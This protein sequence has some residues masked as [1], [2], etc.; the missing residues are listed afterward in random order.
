MR[1]EKT[2][3]AGKL[4]VL[5]GSWMVCAGLVL[6]ASASAA[7]SV[8]WANGSGSTISFANLDGSGGGNLNTTG[9]NVARP[10][11]VAVDPAAGRVY[12]A[13]HSGE[14]ISF[15]NLN[16]SGGG[17]LN[18]AGAS[19][20]GPEGVAI[21]P[22]AGLVYWANDAGSTISFA[23]LNGSG[24]G[25]LKTTG[26]TVS[27]PRGLAVD[28]AAGMIYWANN[29]GS[30]IAFAN[31]DGSGGGE[32]KTT[33]AEVKGAEG[34]AIDPAAGLIYWANTLAGI[35]FANLNDSG[36]GGTLS[37]VG[38]E[39]N[40]PEGVA[41]DPAGGLIYWANASSN[42]ISFAHLN[43]SGGG[44]LAT[45]G[46][47]V[48]GPD[49]PALLQ[50]PSGAGVPVVSGGTLVGTTLSCSQGVWAP[51]L[52]SEFDFLAP[53]SF[54]FAWSE[55]STP[56][57]GAISSSITA[58]SPGSYACQV[59]ASN[60]A[61]SAA[62]SSA[63]VMITAA[64]Q[65]PTSSPTQTPTPTL[66]SLSETAKIWREGKALPA[67]SSKKSKKPPIGT[68]FSFSLNEAASVTFT[69]TEPAAGRKVGKSCVAQTDRNKHKRRCTRTLTA[70]TFT[71][72]AH[73]GTNKLHFEGLVSK[74]A[75]LKPGSYTLLVTA[76]AADKQSATGTLHFTIA[77][78]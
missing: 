18:T 15:A 46:A 48:D 69:F 16:G 13:N 38:A 73:A 62:Q 29:D 11:G 66:S 27:N 56:L 28:P 4:S 49:F 39:T 25:T 71:F 33:G 68:T 9:A 77:K 67:I 41:V 17:N 12:W 54:A 78:D 40:G 65:P 34:V 51:D 75:K 23:N 1:L 35:S 30:T 26:V 22:A 21:D 8:Y 61:G 44:N 2:G 20:D 59:T 76:T 57:A 7:E 58:S 32:L 19:A 64:S 14:P 52:L 45:A 31:L 10:T 74:H 3:L 63:P 50:A 42:K 24:G 37:T 36:G 53:Q 43:G 70:G 47:T 6:A 60:Q 55:N 5:V 72:S